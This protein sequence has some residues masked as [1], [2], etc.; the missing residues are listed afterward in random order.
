M[1]KNAPAH[2]QHHRAMAGHQGGKSGLVTAERKIFH[3]LPVGPL[4]RTATG[5]QPVDV[6]Q[7]QGKLWRSHF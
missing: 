6:S 1:L 4:E 7:N 2:A 3:E 5:R